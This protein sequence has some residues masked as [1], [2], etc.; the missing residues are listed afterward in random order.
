[1]IDESPVRRQSR[2]G[3]RPEALIHQLAMRQSVNQIING[4]INKS[5]LHLMVI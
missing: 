3:A 4:A 5:S 2:D 1:M